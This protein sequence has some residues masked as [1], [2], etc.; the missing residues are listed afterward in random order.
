MR[1][2]TAPSGTLNSSFNRSLVAG[3]PRTTLVPLRMVVRRSNN[4]RTTSP[5]LVTIFYGMPS[6]RC[7]NQSCTPLASEPLRKLD[8][9]RGNPCCSYLVLLPPSQLRSTAPTEPP[10]S[11]SLQTPT[12]ILRHCPPYLPFH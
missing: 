3:C 1:P 4:C 9:N 11:S 12:S 2:L 6:C 10:R 8:D 5:T 7:R